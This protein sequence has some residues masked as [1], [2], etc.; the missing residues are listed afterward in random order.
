LY[1]I[2]LKGDKLSITRSYRD[3]NLK[4]GVKRIDLFLK[5]LGTEK[6]TAF[7]VYVELLKSTDFRPKP[8]ISGTLQFIAAA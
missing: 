5:N 3:K 4:K 2:K 7:I 1:L 8:L 6:N